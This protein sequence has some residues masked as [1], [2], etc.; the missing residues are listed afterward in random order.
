VGPGFS[1]PQRGPR[2][3]VRPPQVS[4]RWQDG[5]L[6]P[7]ADFMKSAPPSKRSPAS[8]GPKWLTLFP[9]AN[10]NCGRHQ[11]S[12]DSSRPSSRAASTVPERR[13][14]SRR[15]RHE[16]LRHVMA[17]VNFPNYPKC[18]A[19]IRSSEFLPGG[20]GGARLAPPTRDPAW[21][22]SR[23]RAGKVQPHRSGGTARIPSRVREQAAWASIGRLRPS[24]VRPSMASRRPPRSRGR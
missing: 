6:K 5:G 14:E 2:T 20:A 18:P 11:E 12:R 22:T 19:D 16:C 9:R 21:L 23:R 10:R 4:H 24:L 13:E 1:L 8:G 3:S 15:R 17:Q 7:A